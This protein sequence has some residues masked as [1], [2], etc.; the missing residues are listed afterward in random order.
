MNGPAFGGGCEIAACCDFLY[1]ARGARFARPEVSLGIL[2]GAVGTQNLPRAMGQRRALDL[3]LTGRPFTAD[4]ALDG[5][6]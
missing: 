3:I 6:S 5:A 1:A 4:E 2:L